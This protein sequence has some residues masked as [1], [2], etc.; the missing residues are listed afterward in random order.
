MNAIS[1]L[2][3][4]LGVSFTSGINLYATVFIVGILIKFNLV[5]SF[6]K[7]LEALGSWPVIIVAG[8]MY[9]VEFVADKI[10]AVDS[11]WDVI[12]TF[13]RPV[14]AAVL[15]FGVAENLSSSMQVLATLL[16]GGVAFASHSTKMG[17]RVAIN[18]SPENLSNSV[19]SVTEDGVSFG[20]AYLAI[21]HPYI[22]LVIVL[23]LL[24]CIFYFGPR[25]IRFAFFNIR[26]I[27]LKIKNTFLRIGRF[28]KEK[29]DELIEDKILS[30][31]DIISKPEISSKCF[32]RKV[33][34]AGNYRKGFLVVLEKKQLVFLYKKLFISKK[35][36][37]NFK[38]II[39]S[40]I[41]KK[42]L[43][44]ILE[45]KMVDGSLNY[46]LFTKDNSVICEKINNLI[47]SS[48]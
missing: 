33:K 12:H 31:Y 24:F 32:S 40:K 19:A 21:A 10:P 2:S 18:T 6:P 35:L 34:K 47:N 17:A 28:K 44:D 3:T 1:T 36:E 43:Y 14:A 16:G 11:F 15:A 41:I 20:I 9:L 39:N 42:F 45:L 29:N 13:V 23:I 38:E 27:F 48:K 25:L 7:G 4:I 22:A 8:M 5:S 26:A 46:F 30:K 37:F